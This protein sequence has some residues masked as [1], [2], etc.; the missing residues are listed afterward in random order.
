MNRCWHFIRSWPWKERTNVSIYFL[1]WTSIWWKNRW[2]ICYKCSCVLFDGQHSSFFSRLAQ[3]RFL[4]KVS[5]LPLTMIQLQYCFHE[6]SSGKKAAAGGAKELADQCTCPYLW[7]KLRWLP[8]K[9]MSVYVL[10]GLTAQCFVN[11]F[12]TCLQ[13]F[14]SFVAY[15]RHCIRLFIQTKA[16]SFWLGKCYYIFIYKYTY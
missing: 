16:L 3:R 14:Y 5:M 11:V 12:L 2:G 10:N 1:C 6:M 9:T 15:K 13:R 4:S 8:H 7:V